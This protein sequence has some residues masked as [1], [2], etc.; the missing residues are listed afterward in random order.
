MTIRELRMWLDNLERRGVSVDEEV[1][2]DAASDTE[3]ATFRGSITGGSMDH[4]HDEHDTPYGV[5]LVDDL[6]D[7]KDG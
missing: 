2:V 4:A 6:S 1:L 3:G 7:E 5:L